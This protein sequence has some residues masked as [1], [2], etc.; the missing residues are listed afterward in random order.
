M[1]IHEELT[2][3]IIAAAIEVHKEL[4]P[5]LLESAYEECGE[6]LASPRSPASD[7][8]EA[9]RKTRRPHNQIAL[10]APAEDQ[11]GDYRSFDSLSN[12]KHGGFATRNRGR[13]LF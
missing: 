4:G 6:Y 13:E 5:G 9:I 10:P 1:L 11:A 2:R 8:S 7:V 12:A 3:E